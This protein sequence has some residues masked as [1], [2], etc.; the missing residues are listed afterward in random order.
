MDKKYTYDDLIESLR[1]RNLQLLTLENE[2]KNS[3]QSIIVTNGKYK[4][5]VKAYNYINENGKKE[6]LWFAT[7]NP[8]I[9]DN[10]NMFLKDKYDN[11]FQCISK[12]SECI[13]RDVLLKIKCNRCG[14]V[15]QKSLHNMRKTGVSRNIVACPNCDEHYE[16]IHAIILK[17][18]FKY[19]HPDTIE[20]D[21]SC[22]NPITNHVMPTDIVNHR[23]KIAIEIQGQYHDREVQKKRDIIKKQY[24]LNRGYKFYDYSIDNVSVLEYIQY[25]FPDLKEIPSWINMEY[26]KKLNI[27]E[28][29]K[30]LNSGMKIPQIAKKLNINV[31]RIYD[32][33]YCKKIYYPDKY[34][35]GNNRPV[36]QLNLDFKIVKEYLSYTQAEKDNNLNKGSIADVVY[37]KRYKIN[38]Y[39]WIP[40]D[41]YQKGEFYISH[42][43]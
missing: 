23:L 19:Y 20:E 32:A 34:L 14:C 13:N 35:K 4:A 41:L 25:F 21:P 1:K 37:H 7:N 24:W 6:P 39:Y 10:I 30:M 40:K 12:A 38:N 27:V 2:Y 3:K 18:I 17:Q 26:N 15:I 43:V 29:Q 5:K 28:I 42:N 11:D 36:L 22:I 31:H 16:S 9:I 33:L 8:F